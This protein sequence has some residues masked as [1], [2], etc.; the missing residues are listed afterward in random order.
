MNNDSTKEQCCDC[1]TE[2]STYDGVYLSSG[3]TTRFLCSRC[4]NVSISGAMGLNFDH[5]SFHPITM[6]DRDGDGHTFHFQT[7][8]YGGKVNIRALE[9]KKDVPNGYEFS[10]SGDAEDDLFDLF[11]KL[12]DRVRREL[13]RKHIEQSDFARYSITNEDIVRA[14]ITFDDDTGGEVP[15]LVI[16]GKELSW[17]EFGR[18][19]MTYE[20]FHFKLEIFEGWEER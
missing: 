18:M 1:K 2:A 9:I 12:I 20:G 13:E 6:A 14:R 8:L 4:Y 15:C 17:H 7:H 11:A 3:S 10:I 5:L 19:L 16:D